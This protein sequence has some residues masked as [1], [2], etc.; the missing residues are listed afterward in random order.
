MKGP[1]IRSVPNEILGEIFLVCRDEALERDDY[2]FFDMKQPPSPLLLTHVAFYGRSYSTLVYAPS[3]FSWT[4]RLGIR[5]MYCGRIQR[6]AVTLDPRDDISALWKYSYFPVLTSL[7]LHVDQNDPDHIMDRPLG[8]G[9]FL[10]APLLRSLSIRSPHSPYDPSPGP[11]TW[12]QLTQVTL[13]LLID[14][15]TARSIMIACTQAE[16]CTISFCPPD[17]PTQFQ[18]LANATT[19]TQL[20]LTNL[21]VNTIELSADEEL[22]IETSLP[23]DLPAFPRRTLFLELLFVSV[24][25]LDD[26]FYEAFT[27]IPEHTPPVILSTL[28]TLFIRE[29]ERDP[30]DDGLS[31]IKMAESFGMASNPDGIG[32]NP[33]FASLQEVSLTL[34]GDPF[35]KEVEKRFREIGVGVFSYERESEIEWWDYIYS[36]DSDLSDSDSE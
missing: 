33:A 10:T 1:P 6:I 9:F 7:K 29:R 36:T 15:A 4:H 30:D 35:S 22:H 23:D 21:R 31:A 27:A 19:L 16:E 2:S 3:T 17:Q 14:L 20:C 34:S 8:L 25:R 12:S 32:I 28:A 18:P 11:V 24:H 26:R 5:L 13:D